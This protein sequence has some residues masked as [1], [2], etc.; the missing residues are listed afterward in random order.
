MFNNVGW[1]DRGLRFLA[2]AVL[3]YLG[4]WMYSGSALGVGLAI[5]GGVALFT[6]LTG[7][8]VL[9]GL[10]GINTRKDNQTSHP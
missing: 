8:C 6:G 5:A 2:A 7:S 3:L 10:L 9:Y 4:G 1:L